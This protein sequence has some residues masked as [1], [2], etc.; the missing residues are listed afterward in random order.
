M[1]CAYNVCPRRSRPQP[2]PPTRAHTRT[3]T[4]AYTH[5][6]AIVDVR[7][8]PAQ[9]QCSKILLFWVICRAGHVPEC[10][11]NAVE[12][13]ALPLHPRE[14]ASAAGQVPG[15]PLCAPAAVGPSPHWGT[16]G[17]GQ[18][19]SQGPSFRVQVAE[20]DGSAFL[21]FKKVLIHRFGPLA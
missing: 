14:P 15:W 18:A 16:P 4:H 6:C 10:R 5:V 8:L 7:K 1:T 2:I 21:S 9:S 20:F 3:C 17:G 11:R 19:E 12:C 13:A